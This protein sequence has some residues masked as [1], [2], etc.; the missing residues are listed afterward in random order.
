MSW[1][2]ES[3]YTFFNNYSQNKVAM[4]SSYAPYFGIDTY[5]PD[6]DNLLEGQQLITSFYGTQPG[7]NYITPTY[8]MARDEATGNITLWSNSADSYYYIN[9]NFSRQ[10]FTPTASTAIP[11]KGARLVASA[12]YQRYYYAVGNCVYVLL[13]TTDFVLPEKS[14]YALQFGS[15]EE[16]TYM[17]VNMKT[18]ELYVATYD[19]GSKRGNFYIYDCKDVRLDNAAAA[20]PKAEYKS[21]AGR[22][23]N[24]IY[25]PSIQ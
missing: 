5:F 13:T 11:E 16:I 14:Q 7:S 15:N 25:K 8:I 18:D 12:S 17:D 21:C 19:N 3:V 22:I 20:K 24:I 1:G 23:T 6:T 9:S 2:S 4:F 10:D